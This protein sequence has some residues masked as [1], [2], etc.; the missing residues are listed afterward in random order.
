MISIEDL[1]TLYDVSYFE[2]RE[3]SISIRE[4]QRN[5]PDALSKVNFTFSGQ[6]IYIK[7]DFFDDSKSIY[8]K[9]AEHL[10]FKKICDGVLII[11]QHEKNYIVWIELKSGYNEVCKKAIFQL[12]AS[13]IKLKSHLKNFPSYIPTQYQ[14]L[15][16]IVS[17]PP[18]KYENDNEDIMVA[19]RKLVKY[20]TEHDRIRFKYDK[21]IR[22]HHAT[23]LMGDDF[24]FND[25]N[26]QDEL[27]MKSLYIHHHVADAPSITIDLDKI[28]ETI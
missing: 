23:F 28:L 6:L 14:E 11:N 24:G 15:G 13:Y 1:Q 21:D 2:E 18:Q 8:R 10:N 26:I 17:F 20:V 5:N 3:D 4:K 9:H 7:S 25:L 22:T 12:P 16:I 19:K 27:K